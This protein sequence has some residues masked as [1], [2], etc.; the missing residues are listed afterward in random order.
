MKLF[1]QFLYPRFEG[2][3][4]CGQAISLLKQNLQNQQGHQREPKQAKR[5]THTWFA[6]ECPPLCIADKRDILRR[7]G[8]IQ[9][10]F[11]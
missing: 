11:T 1:A 8:R 3:V 10:E 4:G 6:P 7:I 5:N 9:R 2:W